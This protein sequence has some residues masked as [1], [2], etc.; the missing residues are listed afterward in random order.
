[1]A[2]T[3]HIDKRDHDRANSFNSCHRHADRPT[4]STLRHSPR[5][6]HIYY[7]RLL[8]GQPH[9]ICICSLFY[10]GIVYYSKYSTLMSLTWTKT[11]GHWWLSTSCTH[12]NTWLPIPQFIDFLWSSIVSWCWCQPFKSSTSC[13]TQSHVLNWPTDIPAYIETLSIA[14]EWRIFE[15]RTWRKSLVLFAIVCVRW[16]NS[17]RKNVPRL[18]SQLFD[19]RS[20][21]HSIHVKLKGKKRQLESLLQRH[22]SFINGYWEGKKI[23]FSSFHRV[24]VVP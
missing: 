9:P 10:K 12:D 21:L 16:G 20:A 13:W 24:L 6:V 3:L 14:I 22:A 7:L 1:M 5:L 23:D 15:G 19:L 18:S 2:I 8:Y 11:L 17:I 4:Q